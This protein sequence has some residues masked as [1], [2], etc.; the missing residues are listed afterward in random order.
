MR[1]WNLRHVYLYLVSFVSLMLVITGMIRGVMACTDFFFP[2]NY[3]TPSPADVYSRY[4]TPDGKDTLPKEVIDQQIAY[5]AEQSKNSM[6]TSAI[7]ELKR[8]SAYVIVALPVWLYHWRRIQIE[9][10]AQANGSIPPA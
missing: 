2:Q 8:A 6:R 4:K 1:N 3:Y 7:M 5:E 10:K 9:V